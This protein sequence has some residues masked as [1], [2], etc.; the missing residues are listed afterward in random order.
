MASPTKTKST[1]LASQS[2]AAGATATGP[3]VDCRAF[4][5][6]LACL[7]ITVPGGAPSTGPTITY[8]ASPDGGTT[9]YQLQQFTGLT[10]AQAYVF[11]PDDPVMYLQLS[12]K[13]NDGTS[14]AIVAVA[15]LMHIDTVA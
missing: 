13:N 9:A 12:I 4:F 14:N 15:D 1:L 2:I 11:A 3:W 8:G 10:A 6:M 5:E 7:S